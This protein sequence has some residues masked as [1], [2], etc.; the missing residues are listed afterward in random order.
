MLLIGGT[1]VIVSGAMVNTIGTTTSNEMIN[2]VSG[3]NPNFSVY[4]LETDYAAGQTVNYFINANTTTGNIILAGL[5]NGTAFGTGLIE[6]TAGTVTVLGDGQLTLQ[7][8]PLN[9]IWLTPT[10]NVAGTGM[11]IGTNSTGTPIW[12][13]DQAGNAT[14]PTLTVGQATPTGSLSGIAFGD[15]TGFGNGASGNVT[16]LAKGSGSGPATP[17]TIVG[18]MEINVQGTVAWVPYCR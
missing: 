3:G 15:T 2:L 5:A 9:G 14:F 16:V 18:F 7:G 4:N 11:I 12:E 10:G 17:G 8:I 1:V 6:G 13:I